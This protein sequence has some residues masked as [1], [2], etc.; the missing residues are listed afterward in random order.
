[1]SRIFRTIRSSRFL[2]SAYLVWVLL[3]I[4]Y[5]LFEVLDVDGSNVPRLLT[6]HQPVLMA[7]SIADVAG[8]EQKSEDQRQ[9][10]PTLAVDAPQRLGLPGPIQAIRPATRDFL[11]ARRHRAESKPESIAQNPPDH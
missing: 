1:M 2:R 4:S 5:V 7:E 11:R 6:P 10:G 8:D 3:A 9:S